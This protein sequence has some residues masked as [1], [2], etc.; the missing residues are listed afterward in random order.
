MSQFNALL[1]RETDK[2]RLFQIAGNDI[3][4]PRSVTKT[5]TKVGLPD[6]KG[7]RECLLDVDDWF[8]EKN[9]L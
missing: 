9:D 5:I 1:L 6:L 4:I 8:C 2:A 3:W 7:R